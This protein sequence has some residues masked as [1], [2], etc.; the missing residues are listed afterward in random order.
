[1]THSLV[2]D[3]ITLY[4]GC[5]IFEERGIGMNNR[6]K[7]QSLALSAMFLALSFVTPFLTGQVQQLGSMFCPMYIPI[8]LCGFICGAPYGFMIG[9][10]AP[11][12]RSL[13]LGM[14]PLIPT[15]CAMSFELAVYGFFSGFFYRIL[16]K[17][18]GCIYLSLLISM[19]LGRLT[20]GL[21]QLGFAGFDTQQFTFAAFWSGAFVHALPGLVL[22]VIL[23][24][25]LVMAAEKTVLK[26]NNSGT[27]G[28]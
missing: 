27:N 2:N 9:F 10:I 20:W 23:V 24:P 3:R 15:A 25:V 5:G 18:K 11:V 14:P 13:T 6:R 8:I 22:Q 19:L 28:N 7:I 21:I 16:P 17:N 26:N 1:M 12:F 4:F